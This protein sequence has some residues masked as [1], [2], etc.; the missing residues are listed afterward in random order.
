MNIRERLYAVALERGLR[1]TTVR[2]YEVLLE[3][4]SLLDLVDPDIQTVQDAIW[5]ID[6]PNH[7]SSSDHRC[8]IGDGYEDQDSSWRSQAL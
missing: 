6:N 2:S 7:S 8:Q 3:R 1:E 5:T 4:M